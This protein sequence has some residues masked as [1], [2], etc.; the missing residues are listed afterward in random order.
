[1]KTLVE[2]YLDRTG[3][4]M[5]EYALMIALIA[6]VCVVAVSIFGSQVAASHQTSADAIADVT[7]HACVDAGNTWDE[8][9]RTC[10]F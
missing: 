3:A 9:S 10:T 8:G 2:L 5:V 6:I 7:R 1:M 4:T